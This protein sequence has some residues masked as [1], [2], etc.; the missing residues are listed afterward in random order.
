M[1]DNAAVICDCVLSSLSRRMIPS[2]LKPGLNQCSEPVSGAAPCFHLYQCVIIGISFY[3]LTYPSLFSNTNSCSEA[4]KIYIIKCTLRFAVS[5]VLQPTIWY[6]SESNP[7]T[8]GCHISGWLILIFW[9]KHRKS[10]KT[11]PQCRTAGYL[12]LCGNNST[13][14][15]STLVFGLDNFGLETQT[16][17]TAIQPGFIWVPTCTVE[18]R[19][20]PG[21]T[22]SLGGLRHL[23]TGFPNCCCRSNHRMWNMDA[24]PFTP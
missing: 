17:K 10:E 9:Q 5:D 23:R 18:M 16:S 3:L 8:F 19:F 4:A 11:C 13:A 1:W 24:S 15:P 7:E 20:L 6:C 12:V 21:R 14:N 2:N 22:K